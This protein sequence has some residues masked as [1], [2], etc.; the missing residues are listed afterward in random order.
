LADNLVVK[1]IRIYSGNRAVLLEE[2]TDY[3]A[4]VQMQ[5]SYNQDDSMRK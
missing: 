2:I 1:N 3:N 5:Y 4:K